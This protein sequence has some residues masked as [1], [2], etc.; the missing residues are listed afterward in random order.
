MGIFRALMHGLDAGL[1]GG[2]GSRAVDVRQVLAA[3]GSAADGN[4]GAIIIRH[5]FPAGLAVV[6]VGAAIEEGPVGI[7]EQAGGSAVESPA[8]IGFRD[9]AQGLEEHSRDLAL[10]VEEGGSALLLK[11]YEDC[12]DLPPSGGSAN[13]RRFCKMD[14]ELTV[15]PVAFEGPA[16]GTGCI[17]SL[18]QGVGKEVFRAQIAGGPV[19]AGPSC[20][21]RLIIDVPGPFPGIPDLAADVIVHL[22]AV[23]I[24]GVSRCI[25]DFLAN[26]ADDIG[27]DGFQRFPGHGGT[28]E[29]DLVRP[30]G[31]LD[32]TIGLRVQPAGM[33][34]DAVGDLVAEFVRVASQDGFAGADHDDLGLMFG[35]MVRGMPWRSKGADVP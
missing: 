29:V 13:R 21:H 8:G 10:E 20:D 34:E 16:E 3:E 9:G 23:R 11:G 32:L 14:D 6:T 15:R 30:C 24:D 2:A 26:R 27:E 4:A 18:A 19:V 35:R 28:G 5:E 7:H 1:A 31:D 33:I 12:V 17:E 22:I 25:A